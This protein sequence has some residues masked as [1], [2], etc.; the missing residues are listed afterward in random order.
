[1]RRKRQSPQAGQAPTNGASWGLSLSF[2][3]LFLLALYL[4]IYGG[5]FHI[6]DEVSIYAMAENL[7]KRGELHTDQILWSQWVRAPREV[8]GAFGRGGHVFSKKG[9]GA[10]LLPAALI[11]LALPHFHLGLTFV[12]FL[13]NPLL[14]A[15]TAVALALYVHRLG[16]RRNTGLIL[17]LVYGTATLAL[18][19][20]RM[21]FGE[22]L[23]ALGTVLALYAILRGEEERDARWSALGGLAI[24]LSVWARLI[25][26]PAILFFALYQY[27][28]LREGREQTPAHPAASPPT[29]DSQ[30]EREITSWR[31]ALQHP[32]VLAFLIP[33]ALVGVGGYALYNVY[34]FGLP[35]KT[36][37]QLTQGE[38][39]TTPPWIGLY[40]I[41]LSPFRG[42]VWYSPVLVAALWG[43]P[44]LRKR[45]PH[46]ALL[47]L[48]LVL[49][50]LALFSTWWMWWGGF[51]WGPRFLLPIIPVLVVPLAPLWEESRGRRV[52]LILVALSLFVQFL[53]VSADFALSETVLENTF[54]HPE[55]SPAMYDIR[56]SPILLQARHLRQGFWDIAWL[57][58][59]GT[60]A[61]P[62]LLISLALLG[63][64]IGMARPRARVVRGFLL[65]GASIAL[66]AAILLGM[67]VVS[68]WALQDPFERSMY[69]ALTQ[70]RQQGTAEDRI[71]TL[72]PFDYTSVMNWSH[73]R[74]YILGMAPHPHPLRP[75]E[76][77][78]LVRAAQKPQGRIWVVAARLPP[79]QPDALAEKWLSEQAYVGYHRWFGDIRL[80]A[81]APPITEKDALIAL[82]DRNAHFG[83][84][85]TLVDVHTAVPIR[86]GGY[87]R[88]ALTWHVEKRPERAYT[89]FVHL[90]TQEGRA[91]AGFDGPPLNGY[92]ATS[93][94]EPGVVAYDHKAI[95]LPAD[96]APGEYA[97]EIGMYDPTTGE[98]LP[99][100]W[101]AHQDTRLLI[102]PIA[103]EQ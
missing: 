60:A 40:G 73:T 25:N 50:Y 70:V 54:G 2:L 28:V 56:W 98:R 95:F 97:L 46:D 51:A 39:F 94:W 4:L 67:R 10:A 55:R 61:L 45:H 6:I 33:A 42:L 14:T 79:G 8:Q 53:A 18:P 64:G 49:T 96:L 66:G 26:S 32:R 12:A 29:A 3:F 91:V 69:D 81:F 88:L 57:K 23:A 86:S 101:D 35:W 68:A 58:V 21:L 37:Y 47:I 63:S 16:Y 9:F 89:I 36:G 99:V 34:R 44:R 5:R 85:L 65:G 76:Q 100:V 93:Q 92:T 43:W 87:L 15:L 13:T 31:D 20:T 48:A 52:I 38:F 74:A 75:E 84:A 80:L 22:P 27:R 19:Y 71:I 72:A 17:G 102:A 11:R 77:S 41:L 59:G 30:R 7:A 83:E 103:I 24:S 1:M 78:L 90:L 82:W 62:L